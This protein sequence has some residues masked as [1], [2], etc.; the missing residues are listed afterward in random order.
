MNDELKNR[1]KAENVDIVHVGQFDY[2]S[3]FR[4][5]R[6]RRSQFLEWA[7]DPRFANVL[8]LWDSAD[9]LFGSGPYLTEKLRIDLS[10]WRQYGFEEKSIAILADFD[11]P[12]APLM[13]RQILRTQIDRASAMG[14]NVIAAF[15]FEIIVLAETAQSLRD[16]NF[17][18][19]RQF[20]PDNKCWSGQT[21]ADQAE[22][23][24]GLEKA[25][26]NHDV[27]LFSV[28]GELGPGCFEATLGAV[29]AMRAA[30][31]ACFFRIAARS[32]ARRSN[33]T[34][35]FMSYLGPSYPGIG[36]H[37]H[38]SLWDKVT[39]KNVFSDA[40]GA[41]NESA[42]HFIAG[43]MNVVPNAFALCAHTVNAY[44]RFA[45]GSWAPKSMNWSDWQF[46][47]AIRSAP[48]ANDSARLEFRIPGAD[49]N[50]HLSLALMLGAG[51][52][53]IEQ[54]RSAP[55]EAIN[56]GPDEVPEGTI[57]FPSNLSEAAER[58]RKSADARRIFGS[59][60]IDHFAKACDAEHASL[61]RAVSSLELQRYLEG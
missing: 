38:L 9:N 36:G 33:L 57:R 52:D 49:C 16:S 11:G 23:V 29:P 59:P 10:S 13:P 61:A 7:R 42:K 14:F 47:T 27:A 20:A 40:R 6:L 60:F 21:A 53:G 55:A 58:L 2:G 17:A 24:A 45:P 15:E 51:L 28:A 46:T 32:Y 1:L 50:P 30:D 48:S 56:S 19:P 35:S 39:G 26:I 5:R 3:L 44:R 43:M 18:P 31:D 12:S 22:F 54:K 34:A 41:T 37:I 25:I 4:E 8:P